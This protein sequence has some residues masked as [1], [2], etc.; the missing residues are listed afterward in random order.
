MNLRSTTRALISTACCALLFVPCAVASPLPQ[1]GSQAQPQTGD[2]TSPA[3]SPQA[4]PQDPTAEPASANL[5]AEPATAN[6]PQQTSPPQSPTA[7][8]GTAAAPDTRPD[9]IAASTPTGA[10]IAPGKQRRVR[11]FSVRTAILVGAVVAVGVVVGLSAASP[12]HP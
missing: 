7:P 4:P 9:G 3:S 6:S 12:S 2:H 1:T 11:R 8:L 10:A 5:P